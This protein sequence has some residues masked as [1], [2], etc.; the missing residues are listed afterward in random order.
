MPTVDAAWICR[1]LAV[2]ASIAVHP[3]AF[4][5]QFKRSFSIGRDWKTKD[6]GL[7][8]FIQDLATG[9]VLQATALALCGKGSSDF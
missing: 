3:C 2:I 5:A 8:A 1:T 9:K 4:A 6:L 7:A